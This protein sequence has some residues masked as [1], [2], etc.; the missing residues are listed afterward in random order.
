MEQ[1]ETWIEPIAHFN[2]MKDNLR[3]WGKLYIDKLNRTPG[4]WL[5]DSWSEHGSL[6]LT[7]ACPRADRIAVGSLFHWISVMLT[8]LF[9]RPALDRTLSLI[10]AC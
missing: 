1:T 4:G 3:I 5:V 7:A 6:N 8:G 9:D 2:H 10:D